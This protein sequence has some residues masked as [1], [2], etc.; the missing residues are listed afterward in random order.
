VPGRPGRGARARALFAAA[1]ALAAARSLPRCP[2]RQLFITRRPSPLSLAQTDAGSNPFDAV[3][4]CGQAVARPACMLSSTPH[5][6]QYSPTQIKANERPCT[7]SRPQTQGAEAAPDAPAAPLDNG[8]GGSGGGAPLDDADFGGGAAEG[9]GADTAPVR[10]GWGWGA[11]GGYSCC[12]RH[13]PGHA[14]ESGGSGE[15]GAACV[16]C[17]ADICQ[18]LPPLS[19]TS[20][21]RPSLPP[22]PL[23]IRGSS[24]PTRTRRC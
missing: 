17:A 16:A 11:L 12:G 7:C 13:C 3:R 8:L 15:G 21:I 2:R 4:G 24:G 1:A 22:P 6:I 14:A 9:N 23:T 20:P 5:H 18:P 19:E 10:P